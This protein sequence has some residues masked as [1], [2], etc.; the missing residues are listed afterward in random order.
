MRVTS[1]P[2][3]ASRPARTWWIG[4]GVVLALVLVVVVVHRRVSDGGA[5]ARA[6]A[7]WEATEPT[8]YSFDFGY[9]GGF[10]QGCTTRVTV[11]SG[12]VVSAVAAEPGGCTDYGVEDA[13]TIE[14]VFDQVERLRHDG[15]YVSH[16]IRY[17]PTWGF[18]ASAGFD[19]A[20]GTSDCGAGLA[21]ADFRV[22]R[23]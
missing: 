6:E 7:R 10:C 15:T 13:P 19:C 2:S 9:C 21:V 4:L 3:T 5:Q 11:E 17:D 16:E 23:P 1:G 22:E 20:E 18:P 8:A 12:E 14:D